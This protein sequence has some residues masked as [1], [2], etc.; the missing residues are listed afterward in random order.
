MFV[1]FLFVGSCT[2]R[3]TIQACKEKRGRI[4]HKNDG[5][6]TFVSFR[7]VLGGLFRG[8]GG[9][10]FVLEFLCVFFLLGLVSW[11]SVFFRLGLKEMVPSGHYL[12]VLFEVTIGHPRSVSRIYCKGF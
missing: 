11:V 6:P 10:W 7:L 8:L 2:L 1:F 5:S 9:L 4:S 12:F 3:R